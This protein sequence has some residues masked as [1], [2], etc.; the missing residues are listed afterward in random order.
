MYWCIEIGILHIRVVGGALTG[1]ERV[2]DI[3][4]LGGLLGLVTLDADVSDGEV[5]SHVDEDGRLE[6]LVGDRFCGDG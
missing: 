1:G 5:L 3:D 6:L 2:F 4:Q